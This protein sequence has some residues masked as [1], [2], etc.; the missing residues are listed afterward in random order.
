MTAPPIAVVDDDTDFLELMR[1]LLTEEGYNVVWLSESRKAYPSIR[2]LQPALVILDIRLEHPEG[3][4]K[5]LNLLR[6]DPTTKDI[7]VIV[8]TADAVQLQTKTEQL[9]KHHAAPLLKPFD[10]DDLLVKIAEFVGQPPAA[11]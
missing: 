1:L 7:P 8:C 10:L 2:Q 9:K 11:D 6:L 3:G 5:V 4:W